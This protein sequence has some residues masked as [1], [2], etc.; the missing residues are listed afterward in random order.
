MS[1]IGDAE[2]FRDRLE[3]TIG[4]ERRLAEPYPGGVGERIAD[5]G[6]DR[7]VRA[8]AHRLG[9]K[10]ADGVGGVGEQYFGPW[11]VGKLRQVIVAE[12]RIDHPPGIVD[13]HLLIECG[14]KRLRD[15]AFDLA[16]ALHRIDDAPGI[17]CVDAAENLDRGGAFVDGDTEGLDVEGDRTRRSI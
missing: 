4:F 12:T 15:G 6:V 7:I 13:H 3:Y 16:A 17:R 2:F 11:H 10:R 8:F 1:S 5:R 14:A 9:A